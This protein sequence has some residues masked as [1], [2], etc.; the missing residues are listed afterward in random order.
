MNVKDPTLRI[1]WWNLR[2]QDYDFDI[3]HWPGAQQTHLDYLNLLVRAINMG[4]F[5]QN[6]LSEPIFNRHNIREMQKTDSGLNKMSSKLE[7][8]VMVEPFF[9][10]NDGILF[11]KDGFKISSW[12]R[13]VF[14]QIVVPSNFVNRILRSYHDAPFSA[15]Q[16]SGKTFR[17]LKKVFFWE[18][19]ER[20]RKLLSVM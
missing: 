6:G 1:A 15:H 8:G 16:G 3:I 19:V 18:H 9:L 17:K 11:R 13:E 14:E 2:L 4:E 10:D 20:Y 12:R 5:E 7:E